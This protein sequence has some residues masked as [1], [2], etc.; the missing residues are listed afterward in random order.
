MPRLCRRAARDHSQH[1]SKCRNDG[2]EGNSLRLPSSI[3][4]ET[5]TSP[6]MSERRLATGT[7]AP[8]TLDRLLRGLVGFH[9]MHGQLQIFGNRQS[10]K[11]RTRIRLLLVYARR[12]PPYFFLCRCQETSCHSSRLHRTMPAT[13]LLSR[14]RRSLGDSKPRRTFRSCAL[15]LVTRTCILCRQDRILAQGRA[16][17]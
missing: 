2:E 6:T 14:Q 15:C 9:R 11:R 17:T 13:P 7:M 5:Q 4:R 12:T 8:L 16:V 10:S 3:V 1:L